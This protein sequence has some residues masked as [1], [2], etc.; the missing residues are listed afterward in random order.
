MSNNAFVK[1][2]SSGVAEGF[3]NEGRDDNEVSRSVVLLPSAKRR[4]I[5]L[6]AIC[7]NIF[8]PWMQFCTIFMMMSFTFHYQNPKWVYTVNLVG[9]IIAALLG[10]V[11]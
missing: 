10:S 4:R 8:C 6:V 2:A 1:Y 9:Y 5:N 3:L 7:F 11:A